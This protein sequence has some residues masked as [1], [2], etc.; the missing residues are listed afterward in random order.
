MIP[1]PI[2]SKIS[3]SEDKS[4]KEKGLAY[5]KVNVPAKLSSSGKK[6]A[7][8]FSSKQEAVSKVRELQLILNNE[9]ARVLEITAP[10]VDSFFYA[11]DNLLCYG[12]EFRRG[13]DALIDLLESGDGLEEIKEAYKEGKAIRERRKESVSFVKAAD[14]MIDLKQRI[15]KR[16]NSTILQ[17]KFVVNSVKRNSMWFRD[18]P[19]IEISSSDCRKMLDEAFNTPK[20]RD[21]ARR[22]LSGVFTL[23]KKR[24]WCSENP[25]SGVERVHLEEREIKPLTV[26]EVRKLLSACMKSDESE[27]EKGEKDFSSCIAPIALLTFGGIRPEEIKRLKWNDIDFE[28]G[29]ISVRGSASKTGGTRHVTM[30]DAM[31]AWL[32]IARKEGD[33]PICPPLW[34]CKW[35]DVR[36]KAGWRNGK[37][38]QEDALRHTFASYHAKSFKDFSLL[39]IEMGHVSAALLRQR[40]TNLVGITEASAKEFWNIFPDKNIYAK[41]TR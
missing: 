7:F 3:Y 1:V 34:R 2:S 8:F 10:E 21:D 24:G 14:D 38:W 5:W 17:I 27:V 36:R 28:E 4:R 33:V 41:K 12:V 22:V 18:K 23:G 25:M 20:Q 37:K 30:C 26:Q 29:V 39:Q 40:Y 6:K 11:R 19:L 32:E 35:T 13:V 31:R 16:R 15:L 9:G